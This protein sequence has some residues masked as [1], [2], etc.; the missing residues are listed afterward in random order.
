MLLSE[1]VIKNSFKNTVPSNDKMKKAREFFANNGRIEKPIVVNENGILVDGYIGFLIL[2]ENGIEQTDVL[3][4]DGQYENQKTVYIRA[5]HMR[6]NSKEYYWR[7]NEMTENVDELAIG[8]LVLVKTKN[9]NKVVR[10]TGIE[11]SYI[12]PAHRKVR[13][14]SKILKDKKMVNNTEIS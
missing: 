5:V 10:I 14:V 13:R 3:I 2:Q 1:I 7:I 4:D 9:G 12:P 8:K 6:D 11:T